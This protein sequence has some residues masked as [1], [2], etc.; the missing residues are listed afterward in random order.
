MFV[1]F[2]AHTGYLHLLRA[3]KK[4]SSSFSNNCLDVHSFCPVSKGV[5]DTVFC[6]KVVIAV[7]MQIHVSMGWFS[8]DSCHN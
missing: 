2:Q 3:E 5:N 8:V 6:S 4:W 7:P 1:L